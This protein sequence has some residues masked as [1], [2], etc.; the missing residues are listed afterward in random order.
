MTVDSEESY[1]VF[2][3][4]DYRSTFIQYL[5]EGVVYEGF[6]FKKGYNGDPLRC[7]GPGEAGGILKEVH[8][9]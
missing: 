9:R 5:T 3:I 6:L 2:A 8:A 1:V 7:L 4:K